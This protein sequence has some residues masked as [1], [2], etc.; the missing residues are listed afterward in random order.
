MSSAEKAAMREQLAEALAPSPVALASLDRSFTRGGQQQR[1][2]SSSASFGATGEEGVMLCWGLLLRYTMQLPPD[3]PTR[4]R[5]L[6]YARVTKAVPRLMAA[7]M[8][9]LPLPLNGNDGGRKRS[10][11]SPQLTPPRGPACSKPFTTN[12]LD[13]VCRIDQRRC[14][15]QTGSRAAK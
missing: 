5:L 7:V 6:E 2:Q 9:S 13:R 8:P 3:S 10:F 12:C 14:R 15:S 4:E 11:A 1:R